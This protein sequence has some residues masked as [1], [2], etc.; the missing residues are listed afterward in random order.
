MS[1]APGSCVKLQASLQGLGPVFRVRVTVKNSGACAAVRRWRGLRR[2]NLSVSG[3]AVSDAMVVITCDAGTHSVND[4]IFKVRRRHRASCMPH[5]HVMYLQL[6][7]LATGGVYSKHVYVSCNEPVIRIA[8]CALCLCACVRVCCRI[9]RRR[10]R[11]RICQGSPRLWC[12]CMPL[13]STSTHHTVTFACVKAVSTPVI[14]ARQVSAAGSSAPLA[15]IIVAV[16]AP[17]AD[18]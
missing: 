10:R 11:R 14:H 8:C 3:A 9:S 6:G 18:F 16:P 2:F 15:C 12:D 17:A 7:L 13:P 5:A 1:S 4:A